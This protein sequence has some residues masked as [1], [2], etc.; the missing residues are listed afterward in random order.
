V[1]G[2]ESASDYVFIIGA[3]GASGRCQVTEYSQDASFL[4]VGRI[5]VTG[6]REASAT[7]KGVLL[8]CPDLSG[9]AL[10]PP[11]VAGFPRPN[12]L[13]L[14]FNSPTSCGTVFAEEPPGLGAGTRIVTEAD[15]NPRTDQARLNCFATAGRRPAR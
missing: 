1:Q 4:G 3:G 12:P 13:E 14:Q 15:Y 5:R 10:I 8:S 7:S 2:T 9:Q 11:V 6:C